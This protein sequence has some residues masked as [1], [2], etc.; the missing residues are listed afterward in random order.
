MGCVLESIFGPFR[1]I[2]EHKLGEKIE[3]KLI[4]EGIEKT[5]KKRRRLVAVLGA[6][7]GVRRSANQR[8]AGATRALTGSRCPQGAATIKEYQYTRHQSWIT[9]HAAGQRPEA[10]RII[11]LSKSLHEGAHGPGG[12]GGPDAIAVDPWGAHLDP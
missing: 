4:Q 5:M 10:Q 2:L 11:T 12:L 9:R 6:S 7:C 3:Q 8:D 1:L